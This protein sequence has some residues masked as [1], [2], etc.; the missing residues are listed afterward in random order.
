M[1][2]PGARL[3]AA[4]R[5]AAEAAEAEACGEAAAQ[6]CASACGGSS[7]AHTHATR[8]S[9]AVSAEGLRGAGGAAMRA[10]QLPPKAA[11]L[12]AACPAQRLLARRR[13]TRAGGAHTRDET[14]SNA[15]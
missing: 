7:A 1:C 2:A 15:R 14:T 10:A 3:R 11:G 4:A 13:R 12:R 9:V 8:A 5:R 6:R